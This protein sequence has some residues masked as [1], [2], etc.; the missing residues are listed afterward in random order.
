VPEGQHGMDGEERRTPRGNDPVGPLT[1]RLP[2][3][4]KSALKKKKKLSAAQTPKKEKEAGPKRS[5]ERKLRCV[6]GTTEANPRSLDEKVF[7]SAAPWGKH[8]NGP[9]V[10]VVPPGD[11]PKVRDQDEGHV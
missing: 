5:V 1:G 4:K 7:R 9:L 6:S 2:G 10:S 8:P 11:S 3:K